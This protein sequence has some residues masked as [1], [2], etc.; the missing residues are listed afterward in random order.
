MRIRTKIFLSHMVLAMTV[1]LFSVV[2]IYTLHITAQS[3]RQL[4]DSY[5][6]IRN[7]Y[8]IADKGNYLVEQIAE[9][10]IIG[11][12]DTE[13]ASARAMLLKRLAKQRKLVSA[14]LD[15]LDDPEA[16][17][18][19]RREIDWMDNIESVIRDLDDAYQKLE[20]ELA[21]GHRDAADAFYK[22]NVENRLDDQLETLI[23]KALARERGEVEHSFAASE[24]LAHEALW[25]A[26]GM[27]V[28]V[29]GL[30]MIN[31]VI[32]NRTVLRPVTAL[33]RAADAVGRGELSHIVAVGGADEVGNLAQRF[34]R[35]TGQLKS[36]HD[37]LRRTNENLEQQVAERTREVIARSHELET[38]NAHLRTVDASRAQF[39]AD[40]SHELRTPL[41][42]IRG[43][44]EVVLRRDDPD[45]AQMRNTLEAIVGKTDQMGRLVEDLLFLARSEAGAITVDRRPVAL[46]EVIGDALLD[47]RTLARDQGV[48]LV[49]QQPV[50]PVIVCGDRERL[51]QTLV[52]LLDNAIKFS[53]EGSAVTIELAASE[54]QAA[55]QVRDAGPGFSQEAADQAFTRFSRS[56]IGKD[57]NRRG[58][59]LG[60]AIAK[61]IVEQHAGTITIDSHSGAG[62]TVAIELPLATE[63]A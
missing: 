34:N 8:L 37:A 11:P 29:L 3:R 43:Q 25:L 17:A 6:Q 4:A 54:A 51:R 19:E 53:P 47:S 2:I 56:G 52:I 59:G 38:L 61:W 36:Q 46:Q 32:L 48:T 31:I 33:A 16:W 14:E 30:G 57:S 58:A 50:D 7:L 41:T 5:E 44:A 13:M 26:V 27:V 21:A 62:A 60:L 9:L 20:S 18:E 12:Q 1:A 40:I 42:I 55:L 23:S 10:V 45:P 49:P 28:L 24:R 15:H 22:N 63:T 35:M 39:F